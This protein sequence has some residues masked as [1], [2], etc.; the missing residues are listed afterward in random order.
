M[1]RTERL[2]IV[3]EPHPYDRG[4]W[5]RFNGQPRPKRSGPGREGWDDCD[6]ELTD[7]RRSRASNAANSRWDNA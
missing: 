4:Y 2:G 6:A 5:A 7:E 1:L 3:T